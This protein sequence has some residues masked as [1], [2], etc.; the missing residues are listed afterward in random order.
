MTRQRDRDEFYTLSQRDIGR[1]SVLMFGEVWRTETF[2]GRI[3]PGDVGKRVYLRG[4]IV[5]VE[6]DEQWQRRTGV[7]HANPA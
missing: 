4:D 1:P 5:Q 2:I 6:N 7:S 3:L